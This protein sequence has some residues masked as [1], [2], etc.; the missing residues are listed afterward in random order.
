[1]PT[2]T[3]CPVDR[4]EA[5]EGRKEKDQTKGTEK[6]HMDEEDKTKGN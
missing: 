6:Q 5:K 2:G 4:G 3:H 1:M